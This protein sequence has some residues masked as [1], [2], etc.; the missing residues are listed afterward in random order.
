MPRGQDAPLQKGGTIDPYVA[1]SM[2]LNKQL[3]GNRLTTAMQEAGASSRAALG[4]AGAQERTA[5]QVQSQERVA[6]AQQAAADRRAAEAEVARR[7]D[8][9]F[10]KAL[11]E[12]NQV[13]QAAQNRLSREHEDA[14]SKREL[15]RADAIAEQQLELAA[16]DYEFQMK[17][18]KHTTNALVSTLKLST[19]SAAK[20]EQ[21]R[22]RAAEI[23]DE[24][25]RSE[26]A[27]ANVVERTIE[28][29]VD[30]KRMD[31]PVKGEPATEFK[32][33]PGYFGG[34]WMPSAEKIKPGTQCDPLGVFQSQL[35]KVG[36]AISAEDLAPANI[37]RVEKML[38]ED[39][40]QAEDVKNILAVTEGAIEAL[41]A[42]IAK[43]P[44]EDVDF[45]REKRNNIRTMRNAL[46]GK[47]DSTTKIAANDKETVGMR[48]RSGMGIHPL[49][50]TTAELK[51]ILDMSKDTQEMID[52]LTESA[53]VYE[54]FEI[55]PGMTGIARSIREEL[56]AINDRYDPNKGEI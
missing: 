44:A 50:R 34:G 10:S 45:L 6:A 16:L 23:N 36:V 42:K 35:E 11:Q 33:G 56:N 28:G 3:A 30:D 18:A 25:D 4:E 37:H 15:D 5:M 27:R 8:N 2:Q 52:T 17:Q 29:F 22:T 31:L 41:T 54:R 7:E 9:N 39:K 47:K 26:S 32:G 51:G 46:E 48:I 1:S 53:D 24:Q 19:K 40:L 38:V 55:T 49:G 43:A 21:A 20:Q 14:V 12:S 13:F